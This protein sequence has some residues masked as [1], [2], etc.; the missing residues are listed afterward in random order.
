[1]KNH[2]FVAETQ[3]SFRGGDRVAVLLPLPL[4]GAYDYRVADGMVLASGDFV[5][6]PLAARTLTGVVWGPG[7]GGIAEAKLKAVRSRLP[8]PPLPA[9][10]RRLIEWVAAYTVSAPGAVLR[11]AMPVP[12]AL[13]PSAPAVGYVRCEAPAAAELKA[14]PARDRVLALLA[15]GRPRPAAEIA[16]T[17]AVSAAVVHGLIA[18]GV[19]AK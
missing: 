19:L 12:D 14:T 18:A 13:R 10:S 1:M 9:V 16:R 7:R 15:D 3:L 4:A 2:T 8:A 5:E 17:A 6:V 11:M